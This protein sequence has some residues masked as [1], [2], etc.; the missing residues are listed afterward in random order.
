MKSFYYKLI[1]DKYDSFDRGYAKS[2]KDILDY[3]LSQDNWIPYKNICS[4][5]VIY[6]FWVK[7]VLIISI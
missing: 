1:E 4:R 3:L 5:I 7:I 6:F 2:Y